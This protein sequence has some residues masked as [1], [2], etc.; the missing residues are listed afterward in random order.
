MGW[1]VGKRYHYFRFNIHMLVST[2]R[3]FHHTWNAK[4]P[5]FWGNFTPKT[6]NYC[7]KNRAPTAFQVVFPMVSWL[8]SSPFQRTRQKGCGA[9]SDVAPWWLTSMD[10]TPAAQRRSSVEETG[11]SVWQPRCWVL[12]GAQVAPQ[13]NKD[14][15]KA[16]S[17]NKHFFFGKEVGKKRVRY[18]V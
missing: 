15:K 8:T 13:K 11:G 10:T 9:T 17:R 6:S 18:V 2:G 4:C 5:I 16:F 1:F 14:T 7:L 12:K 3:V